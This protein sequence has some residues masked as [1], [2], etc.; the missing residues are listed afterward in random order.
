M[1]ERQSGLCRRIR[2]HLGQL[3]R[4]GI[5]RFI[6]CGT[7]FE[8]RS[9]RFPL[10]TWAL[11]TLPSFVSMTALMRVSC[12]SGKLISGVGWPVTSGCRAG[13]AFRRT[14]SLC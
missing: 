2:Q 3:P 4:A 10:P 1:K 9:S 14:L 13:W 7:G 8:V 11:T 5:A 12:Q 6:C